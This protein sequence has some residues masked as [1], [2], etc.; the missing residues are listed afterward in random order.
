MSETDSLPKEKPWYDE[1]ENE[2]PEMLQAWLQ[3][4]DKQ[5]A[6]PNLQV[7]ILRKE[8]IARGRNFIA[9]RLAKLQPQETPAQ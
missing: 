3:L 1:V 6:D 2:T 9:G 4:L 7:T 5:V 8:D